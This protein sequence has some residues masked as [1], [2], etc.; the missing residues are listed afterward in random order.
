MGKVALTALAA[1]VAAAGWANDLS[2]MKARIE[3]DHAVKKVDKFHGFDRVVFDFQGYEAWVV[4]PEGETKAGTPWTW[5]MQWATAFFP[6]TNVPDMLRAGYHHVTIITF[7][8][9]MNETGLRVSADFQKFLVEKLGFAPKA[10]LIGMSWGG[11][12]STRYAA[13]YPQNVA[14]IYLDCPLLNLGGRAGGKVGIGPWEKDAP[15]DW[16]DDPRMPINLAKPLADAKIPILLVYGGADNILTPELNSKIFIPRFKKAGGDITVV[17][18]YAYGHHP[19][20][21]EIGET[22][23]K[24]F[25]EK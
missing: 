18:R 4:C 17:Y 16:T 1:F 9:K 21:V 14:K 8:H 24:D 25:F 15:E 7:E 12:F 19:H 11:F 6:R 13:R 20:G 2:E 22:T 5:T 10:F 23:I 3:N